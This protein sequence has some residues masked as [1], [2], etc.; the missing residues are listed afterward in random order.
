MS[1]PSQETDRR[2]RLALAKTVYGHV[3][4]VFAAIGVAAII[5]ELV[6]LEWRSFI[7]TAVG[8]W[9]LYVRPVTKRFLDLAI[10]KPVELI[11]SRRIEI[12]IVLRDYLSVGAI[13]AISSIRARFGR[14]TPDRWRDRESIRKYWIP[15]TS[16][17][18]G[19][20][21]PGPNVIRR[22]YGHLLGNPLSWII[23]WPLTVLTNA[24]EGIHWRA[25]MKTNAMEY[26]S[27]KDR[28]EEFL[29]LAESGV[30]VGLGPYFQIMQNEIDNQAARVESLSGYRHAV[31]L[32][33]A[34]IIYIALLLCVNLV[35]QLT[36]VD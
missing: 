26:Q 16:G 9:D 5:S 30:F 4:A 32:T 11:F 13:L 29:P 19:F 17:T 3:T 2:S 33:L 28:R 27:L 35:L 36:G 14:H 34:P 8:F 18:T 22:L 20:S 6:G 7:D 25:A 10:S 12:P 24:Y 31:F 1:A 21:G 23:L 15:P